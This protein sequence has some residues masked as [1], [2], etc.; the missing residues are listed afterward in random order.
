MKTYQG[1]LSTMLYWIMAALFGSWFLYNITLRLTHSPAVALFAAI[2]LIVAVLIK[3]LYFDNVV[4][5]INPAGILSVKRFGRVINRFELKNFY[6]SEYAK[7]TNVKNEEEQY[8]YFVSKENGEEDFIDCGNFSA[9]DY[10]RFLQ[11]VGAKNSEQQA[12]KLK[13]IK[14]Q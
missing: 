6:I 7:G 10:E 5:E 8:V 3:V 4:L 14:K 11:D 12:V 1:K 2:A 9:E 13:T